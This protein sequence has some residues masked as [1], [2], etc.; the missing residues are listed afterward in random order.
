MCEQVSSRSDDP[1]TLRAKFR[2]ESRAGHLLLTSGV[3]AGF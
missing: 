2:Q 3:V 1:P